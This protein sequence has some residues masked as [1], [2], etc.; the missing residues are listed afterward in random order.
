VLD[1]GRAAQKCVRWLEDWVTH[2]PP[3]P[4]LEL[5][6]RAR[7]RMRLVQFAWMDALLGA[8]AGAWGFAS[9]LE[10]LRHEILPSHAWLTWRHR[11]FGSSA[12]NHLIGELA[13]LIVATVRWPALAQWGAPLEELQA[14][15]EREVLLQFAPDG[16]NREQALNYHLFSWSSAGRR[17]PALLHGGRPI[18]RDTAWRIFDAGEYFTKLKAGPEGWDYGDSDDGFATPLVVEESCR[19]QEWLQWLI[20]RP[21]SPGLDYW[22]GATPDEFK[23]KA[24]GKHGAPT[25]SASPRKWIPVAV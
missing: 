2:N 5:D 12:N 11:S 14:L 3:L 7:I 9:E 15:W 1:D 13:G 16:G 18:S 20:S 22:S 6:E 10:T 24:G 23:S 4:R 25:F 8:K 21:H 19:V 17:R